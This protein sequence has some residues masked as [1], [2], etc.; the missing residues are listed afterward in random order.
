MDNNLY[1]NPSYHSISF[2]SLMGDGVLFLSQGGKGGK[3]FHA[4]RL[5]CLAA[6]AS[7]SNCSNWWLYSARVN[8]LPMLGLKFTGRRLCGSIIPR[9]VEPV[10]KSFNCCAK[11]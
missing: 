6:H 5:V 4:A 3:P 7:S 1:R 10:R 9:D 11:S 2:E 8:A